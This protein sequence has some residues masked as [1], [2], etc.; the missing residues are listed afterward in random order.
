MLLDPLCNFLR[1]TSRMRDARLAR[2]DHF[3]QIKRDTRRVFYDVFRGRNRYYIIRC[4]KNKRDITSA[5]FREAISRMRVLR[6]G[7]KN[8]SP[9]CK[10]IE[11]IFY[12]RRKIEQPEVV[13]K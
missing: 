13:D 5:I 4:E 6:Q 3:N 7:T 8:L 9:V 2:L 1:E 11:I 12:N 10:W